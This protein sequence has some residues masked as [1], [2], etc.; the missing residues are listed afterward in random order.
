MF[1]GICG[2]LRGLLNRPTS[3]DLKRK[4]KVT[5]P[6]TPHRREK[7][8]KRQPITLRRVGRRGNRR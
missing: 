5:N 7:P 3:E 2:W 4:R 6:P 8:I 1:E